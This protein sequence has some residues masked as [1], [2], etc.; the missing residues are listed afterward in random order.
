MCRLTRCYV[1]RCGWVC[2]GDCGHWLPVRLPVGL[3]GHPRTRRNSAAGGGRC[4]TTSFGLAG[5]RSSGTCGA[6]RP[7]ESGDDSFSSGR[8]LAISR[9]GTSPT[10][11]PPRCERGPPRRPTWLTVALCL[12]NLGNRTFESARCGLMP[13]DDGSPLGSHLRRC[14][15]AVCL[16]IAENLPG[17]SEPRCELT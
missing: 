6:Q 7:D 12:F 13:T 1:A 17:W 2:L 8:S 9:P 15:A 4:A 11:R 16:L 14:H 3:P 10:T 5:R